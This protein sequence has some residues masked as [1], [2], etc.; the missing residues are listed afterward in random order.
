MSLKI[1]R[2]TSDYSPIQL[3]RKGKTYKFQRTF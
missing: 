3:I 2:E 1:Y